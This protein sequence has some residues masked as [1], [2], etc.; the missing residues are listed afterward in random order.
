M[1]ERT[2]TAIDELSVEELLRQHRFAQ[3]GDPRYQGEEGEYRMKRLTELRGQ[4]NAA[5]VAA[6]KRIGWLG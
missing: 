3:V 2:K 5:Y 4:D 1:D 6:S